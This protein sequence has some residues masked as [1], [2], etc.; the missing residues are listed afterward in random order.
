M[1]F[2]FLFFVVG[3]FDLSMPRN[4]HIKLCG[5]VRRFGSFE[6]LLFGALYRA[7]I[8]ALIS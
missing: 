6:S 4:L 2:L 1:S 3:V 8:A 5:K 7:H